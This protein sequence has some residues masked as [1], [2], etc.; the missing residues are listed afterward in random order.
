MEPVDAVEVSTI[1]Y[2]P[3]EEIYDFL[4]DFPRYAD[5]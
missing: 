4:I 1:V 5:Y 2:L 3:P